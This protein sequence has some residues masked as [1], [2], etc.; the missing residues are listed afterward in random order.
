[1]LRTLVLAYALLMTAAGTQVA[2]TEPPSVP[3]KPEVLGADLPRMKR[4]W[5]VRRGRKDLKEVAIANGT[6]FATIADELV[7]SL[8]VFRG[9]T[10]S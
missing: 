6:V 4:L 7:A 5:H 10:A 3:P 1:M 8:L 9:G 2:H